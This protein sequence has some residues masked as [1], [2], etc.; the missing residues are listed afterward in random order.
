MVHRASTFIKKKKYFNTLINFLET[1][2]KVIL[3]NK[4]KFS[5]NHVM[6]ELFIKKNVQKEVFQK[7]F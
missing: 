2:R 4:K 7:T 1:N 6:I 5:H 3:S